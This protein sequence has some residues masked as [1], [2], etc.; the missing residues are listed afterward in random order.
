[1]KCHSVQ[2]QR[3]A[4]CEFDNSRKR[5]ERLLSRPS[6]DCVTMLCDCFYSMLCDF[7]APD[8]LMLIVLAGMPYYCASSLRL[9]CQSCIGT[10]MSMLALMSLW[11]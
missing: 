4:A 7:D 11:C 6:A 8:A 1:V 3:R 9:D 10:C 5:F 2:V